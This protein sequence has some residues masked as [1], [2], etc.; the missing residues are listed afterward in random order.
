MS[1]DRRILNTTTR[2]EVLERAGELINGDRADDYGD[3]AENFGRIAELW[4]AT[5]GNEVTPEQV[6]LCMAQVKISRLAHTTSHI[7]SWV[8]LIG[9]AALGAELA[10][11]SNA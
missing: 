3:A 10:D 1:I 2:D 8:D 5:L 6:A 7:D 4:S 11:R 9:Y